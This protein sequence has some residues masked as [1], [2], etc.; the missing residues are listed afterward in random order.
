VKG[1][2]AGALSLAAS[3]VRGEG[4]GG[5]P[6]FGVIRRAAADAMVGCFSCLNNLERYADGFESSIHMCISVLNFLILKLRCKVLFI[7]YLL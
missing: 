4:R 1:A 6:A 2:A 5:R 3:S 7:N